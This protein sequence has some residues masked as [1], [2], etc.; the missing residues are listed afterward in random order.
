MRTRSYPLSG[1][2]RIFLGYAAG[3]GAVAL[4]YAILAPLGALDGFE[5]AGDPTA[6]ELVIASLVGLALLAF[7]GTAW[8]LAR[9]ELDGERI[10]FL[11][12]GLP[13]RRREVALADVRRWGIGTETTEG[14]T[15]SVLLIE[16]AAGAVH[17]VRLGMYAG[18]REAARQLGVQLGLAPTPTRSTFLGAR[19]RQA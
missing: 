1:T 12:F 18:G 19:F 14:R 5:R 10:A 6:V 11:A 2:Y 4:G 15:R 8:P 17:R 9:L 13:C 7:A 16:D 3:L